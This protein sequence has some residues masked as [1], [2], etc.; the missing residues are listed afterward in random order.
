MLED[1]QVTQNTGEESPLVD[2][3]T[4]EA[5]PVLETTQQPGSQNEGAVEV[6]KVIPKENVEGEVKR[7]LQEEM[8]PIIQQTV[9]ELMASQAGNRPVQTQPQVTEESK[10]KGYTKTQLENV[11]NHPDA[12]EQDRL[13]ANR[14]LGVLEAKEEAAK[15]FEQKQQKVI[16]QTRQQAALGEV[17]RDYPQ[18]YSKESNSWNYSDPL[19]QRGMA[20][21]NSDPRLVSFGNEGIQVAMDRAFA[22]MTREGSMAIKKKEVA[23]NAK[24]RQTLKTQSQA[25]TQGS[26]AAP[27]KE[28][29]NGAKLKK[30]MEDYGKSQDPE[31]FRQIA[32]LKGL[33]PSNI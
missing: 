22:Q 4:T 18:V 29:N 2:S 30:L 24:E 10:Y 6:N 5:A 23:I 21:F 32:K 33:I 28:I 12:T 3:S 25:L 19:F 1:Q 26:Q 9:R 11:L 7:R 27:T 31:I 15:E 8:M 16:S 13:F 17:I 20:I 14:G